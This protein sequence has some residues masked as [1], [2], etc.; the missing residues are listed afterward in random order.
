MRIEFP[1]LLWR[2]LDNDRVFTEIEIRFPLKPLND[3][4]INYPHDV[5]DGV[6]F[7]PGDRDKIVEGRLFDIFKRMKRNKPFSRLFVPGIVSQIT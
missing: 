7:C 5:C 1:V 3:C 6:K 2:K 4:F